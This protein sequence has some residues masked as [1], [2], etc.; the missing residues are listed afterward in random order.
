MNN[1]ERKKT[2]VKVSFDSKYSRDCPS[3]SNCA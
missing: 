2:K 3:K 1:K